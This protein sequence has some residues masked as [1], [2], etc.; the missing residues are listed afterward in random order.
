MTE[1]VRS[2]TVVNLSFNHGKSKLNK[3]DGTK[4]NYEVNDI[5]DHGNDVLSLECN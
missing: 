4:Y 2:F 5:Y 3:L 1:Y